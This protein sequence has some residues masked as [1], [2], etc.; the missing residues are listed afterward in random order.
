MSSVPSSNTKFQ[1]PKPPPSKSGVGVGGT[2]TSSGGIGGAGG[3]VGGAGVPSSQFGN[4]SAMPTKKGA[5]AGAATGAGGAK[6]NAVQV[7]WN[8]KI[9]T[10]QTLVPNRPSQHA[11]A[12]AVK[13]N[14]GTAVTSIP[15]NESTDK[16]MPLKGFKK[17]PTMTPEAA[18]MGQAASRFGHTL[19]P[20]SSTNALEKSKL[21]ERS[22][23]VL[24]ETTTQ[25][26]LNLNSHMFASDLREVSVI[27][28]K[29][30]AYEGLKE[31]RVKDVDS[32][33]SKQSQTMNNT[34]KH[35]HE[36]AAPAPTQTFGNQVTAY[37]ITDATGINKKHTGIDADLGGFSAAVG[38]DTSAA[39][40][41]TTGTNTATTAGG[42][43]G[44][45][46]TAS[47]GVGTGGG[48]V[49]FATSVQKFVEDTVNVS[50]ATPGCL[51]DVEAVNKEKIV[52]KKEG[53]KGKKGAADKG[54]PNAGGPPPTV[55]IANTNKDV[56]ASGVNASGGGGAGGSGSN[57]VIGAGGAAATGNKTS[58]NDISN[59]SDQNNPGN[60][61]NPNNS[62]NNES[63]SFSHA[64]GGG[65]NT[66]TNA[67]N[68]GG[69]SAPATDSA[70]ILFEKQA[71]DIMKST[72]LLKRMQM[73]ER[74]VQQNAYHRHQ[75]DYR[76]LPD[77]PPLTLSSSRANVVEDENQL[78][79]GR[80]MGG[81]MD[82]MGD[83]SDEQSHEPKAEELVDANAKVKKLFNF[84][85]ADLVQGRS[86][87]AMAWNS[88]N[89]DLLAV[90]YGKLDI[91]S[92][93]P[94]KLGDAVDEQLQGGL[95]L[96]WSLRN[97]E[98][99]EKILR[100]PHPV[101]ALDFSITSPMLLALGQLNGDICIYDMMKKED[102]NVPKE[103]SESIK[104]AS[105]THSDPVW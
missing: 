90:G 55:S 83:A 15:E 43:G 9:V 91:N 27:N 61:N 58:T 96:F 82:F 17:V 50:L 12:S 31:R 52:E 62:G 72:S 68:A 6:A 34:Q 87:T 16:Q 33:A 42:V 95:V 40:T 80:M 10:P 76:D 99:P 39:A 54:N 8:G 73:I 102:V 94:P 11:G 75:L 37:E 36:M 79:G 20:S 2:K 101:T 85:F 93:E 81:G 24:T 19:F 67:N 64:G 29:N 53:A 92:N 1:P 88:V 18:G 44:S 69:E 56:S 22:V 105:L 25:T 104:D 3:G 30:K 57:F 7:I 97:P 49:T 84:Y 28:E 77:V 74:A 41:T 63:A 47:A 60:T 78:F 13:V 4:T 65:F 59:S 46:Q 35:A 26:V 103:T 5:Q 38:T 48:K 51:L 66:N 14:K 23:I 45:K 86:V 32:F 100:T 89:N 70:Q 21:E 98:Y 71:A